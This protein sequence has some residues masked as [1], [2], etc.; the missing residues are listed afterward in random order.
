M[1]NWPKLAGSF[2]VDV[3]NTAAPNTQNAKLAASRRFMRF[4]LRPTMGAATI[5]SRPTGATASPAHVAV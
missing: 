3:Q 2:S 1:A 5:A 4:M